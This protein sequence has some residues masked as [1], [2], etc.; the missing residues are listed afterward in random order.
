MA[1]PKHLILIGDTYYANVRVPSDIVESYG[2]ENVRRSLKTK[3]E[4]EAGRRRS[5]K[6]AEIEREFADHRAKL[7]AMAIA[8]ETPQ[9]APTPQSFADLGRQ[10]GRD[11]AE[12]ALTIRADLYEAAVANPKEFWRGAKQTFS[13]PEG[14]TYLD[15]LA[16]DGDLDRVVGYIVRRRTEGRIANLKRMI[17]TGDMDEL[18]ALAD[19]RQPGLDRRGNVA[20]H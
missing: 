2:K 19:D 1:I 8:A 7:K 4:R 6:V 5:A 11:I 15:K 13:D 14:F 3:D 16:A 10:H 18:L 9:P 20:S 17:D 12:R